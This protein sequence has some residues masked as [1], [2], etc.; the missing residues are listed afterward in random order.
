MKQ[1][2]NGVCPVCGAA[3][4]ENA[5]FCLH[6]MTSF[7]EKTRIPPPAK[8][9]RRGMWA[10]VLSSVLV[11]L[12]VGIFLV[13]RNALSAGPEQNAG[14]EQTQ[15]ETREP[16]N[17][18]DMFRMAVILASER[19]E[20]D[21]FWD[22]DGFVDVEY[23]NKTKTERCT[24]DIFLSGARLDLF[25]RNDGNVITMILSDVPE[26]RL[27][28]AKQ[29]CAAVH[30]AVT[31]YYSDIYKILT[32]DRTY[33]R[34]DTGEPYIKF[35]TDMIGKTEEY[36]AALEAGT[37]FATH[38]TLIDDED[39][40]EDDDFTVFFIT[41]RATEKTKLYDLILRFDYYSNEEVDIGTS[42]DTE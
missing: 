20:C 40:T 21:A 3:L 14:T 29:L 38:Y 13:F 33:H 42:D 7:D 1:P 10:V 39:K 18:F 35:F 34:I 4:Q 41:E 16:L 11:L 32:D 36:A 12:G 17:D 19:L 37:Q 24:T 22:V 30:A 2:Q 26:E 15:D 31:N 6:C 5:C 23:N 8:Q 27:D 25:F 28:D 9:K